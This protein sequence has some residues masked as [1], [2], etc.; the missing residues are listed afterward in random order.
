MRDEQK[1]LVQRLLVVD[2]EPIIVATLAD[3]LRRAGFEVT[4]AVSADEAI[5]HVRAGSFALAIVDYAMPGLNG[6]E[7]AVTF[8]E[9]RQPFMFLSAYS[10][11]EL[12]ERA[13]LAGALAY[14]VK[15]IDPVQLVP[16]VRTAAQRAREM[17]ALLE[18]S[19]RLAKAIDTNRDVSVAV[20]LLMAQRGLT[21]EK[22]YDALRNHARRHRRRLVELAKEITAGAEAL[23]GIPSGELSGRATDKNSSEPDDSAE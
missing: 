9:L 11:P 7:A 22:A 6:L 4:G 17:V 8:T 15:P 3:G 14:L 2:D 20:G 12:V 1:T 10:D 19:E 18:Q 13:I 21:R 16:S 23:Y 5:A